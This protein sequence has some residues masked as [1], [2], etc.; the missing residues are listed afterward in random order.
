MVVTTDRDASLL[1][2][3]CG[4]FLVGISNPKLPIFAAAFFPQFITSAAPWLPRFA[5]LVATFVA[6]ELL[7]Y[8]AYALSGRSNQFFTATTVSSWRRPSRAV[9]EIDWPTPRP[10]RAAPTGVITEMRCSSTLSSAG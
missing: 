9:Q 5:I 3:F 1:V 4:G 6:V 7:F 8:F 10:T 2:I